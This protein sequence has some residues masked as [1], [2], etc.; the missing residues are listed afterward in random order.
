[1][2]D[3]EG[4]LELRGEL[5]VRRVSATAASGVFLKTGVAQK[6]ANERQL[7]PYVPFS[8]TEIQVERI[9]FVSSPFEWCDAQLLAAAELT[10]RIS[11]SVLRSG[12]E[13]KD[14]SAWNVVFDG[15]S[16]I[17]C[18]HLSFQPIGSRQWWAFGQFVRHFLLPLQVSATTGMSTSRLFRMSRD[19]LQF[20]E[21]RRLLRSRLLV[22]RLW[23]LLFIGSDSAPGA[24]SARS[25]QASKALHSLH[26]NLYGY[27]G[28][29]LAGQARARTKLG[30]WIDY[31][32]SRQHYQAMD[33]NTKQQA[34]SA[35]LD[36]TRPKR[37][38]DVGANTGEFANLAVAKGITVIAIEQDHQCVSRLYNTA[39]G[40]R[41]IFPVLSNLGDV[42]G[43]AGW[44]GTEHS[45]LLSRLRN[46]GDM[47]LLLA[48]IHHLA[49]SESIPLPEI[50]DF[51]ATITREFAIVEFIAGTDPMLIRLA[52][53]RNRN[54]AEFAQPLQ[55]AAFQRRFEF[56]SRQELTGSG[57]CLV[58]MRKLPV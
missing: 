33:Q 44:L 37:L 39:A 5:L 42:C 52:A 15:C 16:P 48:V 46:Q 45:G 27:C 38:I 55:E 13:L 25:V 32:G 24:T 2:R 58:L 26:A 4:S 6:L 20:V 31:T 30:H 1:V 9:E 8:D 35:W 7:V 29:V 11:N 49:I 3:P 56:L 21:A 57:R 36:S 50:A 18:D 53:Q 14:A 23:P 40:N 54:A 41:K 19:G 34:V 28:W 22:T 51:T 17:F 12:Y 47:V 10:L 43:G